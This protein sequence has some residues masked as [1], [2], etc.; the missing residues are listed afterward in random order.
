MVI[1]EGSGIATSLR[2]S[3]WAYP[4][5]NIVHVLGL[6]AL[7]GAILALDLRLIGLWRTVDAVAVSRP[8]VAVAAGGLAVAAASGF[9][10]FIVRA[11]EYVGMPV[12]WV[13]LAFVAAGLANVAAARILRLQA[14]A[15]VLTAGISIACWTSAI[16]A[17][18][19]IGYWD[20]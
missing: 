6:A 8:A 3:R 11:S 20:G 2:F 5:V 1:L 18:R 19:L 16:A 4:I 13:K 17:G 12:F 15:P 10:L 14:R 7:F 9:L